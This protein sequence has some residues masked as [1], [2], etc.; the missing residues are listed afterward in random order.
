MLVT[1]VRHFAAGKVW[2]V[3]IEHRVRRACWEAWVHTRGGK[4]PIVIASSYQPYGV[5]VLVLCRAGTSAELLND[6]RD[7]ICA[8]CSAAEVRIRPNYRFSSLVT[9]EVALPPAG[10]IP[11]TTV[12]H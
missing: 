12:W 7:L 5:R 2:C 9:I 10:L 4:V 11:W 6:E 1:P 3:L 8:A